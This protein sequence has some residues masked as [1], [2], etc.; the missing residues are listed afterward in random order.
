MSKKKKNRPTRRHNSRVLLIAVPDK[1]QNERHFFTPKKNLAYLV[2]FARAFKAKVQEVQIE[3]AMVLP[4]RELVD[5]FCDSQYHEEANYEVIKSMDMSSMDMSIVK[6]PKENRLSGKSA[7]RPDKIMR[8]IR[9]ML[10]KGQ[11]I[12][13]KSLLGRLKKEELSDSTIRRYYKSVRVELE[14]EGYLVDKIKNGE[15]CINQ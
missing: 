11:P 1:K 10:L 14:D 12:S 6:V 13:T 3:S 8:L 7:A 2:E 5:A 15:Y 4:L 9:T